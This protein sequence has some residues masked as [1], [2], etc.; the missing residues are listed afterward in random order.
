MKKLSEKNAVLAGRKMKRRRGGKRIL[1]I[2]MSLFM[3]GTLT[4]SMSFAADE[5]HAAL[6]A[7]PSVIAGNEDGNLAGAVPRESM[8]EPTSGD[9]GTAEEDAELTDAEPADETVQ[10][11]AGSTRLTKTFNCNYKGYRLLLPSD[12]YISDNPGDY[13]AKVTTSGC[14]LE[15]TK[16]WSPYLNPAADLAVGIQQ[17][18]PDFQ[19]QDGRDQYFGYYQSRFILNKD[20][21]RNNG[22]AV[23]DVKNITAAG[24]HGMMYSAVISNMP[25]NSSD[26]YTYL[27][28]KL[29]SHFFLRIVSRYH[30][31]GTDP[32]DNAEQ[33]KLLRSIVSSLTTFHPSGSNPHHPQYQPERTAPMSEE[34]QALYDRIRRIGTSDSSQDPLLWGIYTSHVM[35]EGI[36]QTIPALEKKLNYNFS[37]VLA[38]VH[39]NGT[40]PTE[41]MNKAYEHG[42]VVE[43]TYQLT[44]NNNE[45]L[46]ADSVSM[47]LY[48]RDPA[49]IERIRQFAREARALQ[50]PFLFRLCNEMNSDWTSYGGVV[51]MADPDI[52]VEN[53]RTIYQIFQEEGVDNCIWVYNPNNRNAPP[54]D[55]NGALNYYPGNEY[56]DLIGVTGYNTGTYYHSRWL[57]EWRGFTEIYDE[58]QEYYG[59]YF[60]A[61]PWIITEFSS[62]SIGGD[63]PEWIRT[64]FK[65]IGKYKNI[66]IAVW[67][68]FADYDENGNVARPYWLDE[69]TDTLMAFRHGLTG[70]PD[71]RDLGGTGWAVDAIC[72]VTD[73]GYFTGTS[74]TT[75]DPSMDMSR[76]MIFTVIARMAGVDTTT[77][78]TWYE[79]G[80]NWAMEQGITDGTNPMSSITREQM[81]TMLY[82][83]ATGDTGESAA[84]PDP[85]ENTT[86]PDPV[87]PAEDTPAEG[88]N[89]A[90]SAQSAPG[91]T[92]GNGENGPGI[93]A[94][95][96]NSPAA[97]EENA[98][99][100]VPE[101]GDSAVVQ[102]DPVADTGNSTV[103]PM[104][105]STDAGSAATITENPGTDT[106]N[107]TVTPADPAE[108]TED[109]KAVTAD[110]TAAERTPDAAVGTEATGTA[111]QPGE[112][113]TAEGGTE[114]APVAEEIDLSVLQ[115]FADLD[116]LSDWAKKAM[117]WAVTNGIITGDDRGMLDP[118]GMA[119]RAQVAVI[120]SRFTKLPEVSSLLSNPAVRSFSTSS[121]SLI[122]DEKRY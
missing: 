112:T 72:E 18:I 50:H 80:M 7:D 27:F 54:D 55:W 81:V 40:V 77:G 99:E 106:G 122:F 63:K 21:Q 119:T 8:V 34:T 68:S 51:N 16:E 6:A 61:F 26:G 111:P 62:S 86:E 22:V 92:G 73:A 93:S 84:Q 14:V 2:M 115:G 69:T 102:P 96:G 98:P 91:N 58:I 78:S 70:A 31:N 13:D 108:G 10:A 101:S 100:P 36:D 59:K 9:A 42:K 71:F 95:A 60:S 89:P 32:S 105:S 113:G 87:N 64:M 103:A 118:Q 33:E 3:L 1:S 35:E 83:Y 114:P 47:R 116:S 28:L 41:F 90:D 43:L 94:E 97:D 39:Y 5:N 44:E 117:V 11:S 46:F 48:R 85:A 37:V 57:E 30:S 56:V 75:F 4:S 53:W 74:D 109:G 104:D 76:A 20:W 49:T 17:V 67:F 65:N 121:T 45:N 88:V 52:F 25:E 23:S 38:Y 19:W 15:I 107:G 110:P 66:K 12:A 82:R 79:A 24:Y 120:I 29:D